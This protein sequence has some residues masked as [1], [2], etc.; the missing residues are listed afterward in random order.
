MSNVIVAC[1][2]IKCSW[3][4]DENIEKAEKLIS[5]AASK[6]VN[7]FLL[8][9]LFSTPYF[10]ST[11]D[12]NFF[13]L[14]RSFKNNDLLLKFSDIASKYK[15]VLPISFFEKDKNS[16]YNSV[17]IIDSN[18][19]IL[20]KYRKSHIPQNPGYEEKYYFS[21]GNTGFKVWDVGVC[22]FGVGIC[23]DQWFPECARSMVLNGADLLF[24]PT[25][26]GNE[27]QNPKINS[28]NHWQ[29]A[30][31]GHAASNMVGVIAS[32]RI[33]SEIINNVEM[34]FYGHSFIVNETGDIVKDLGNDKEGFICHTFNLNNLQSK[35][36]E[37]GLFRDRREDLYIN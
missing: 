20:G 30:M 1:S 19:S 27:P 16:Y 13:N 36:A 8:Q 10:C 6:N 32:N 31:R 37:W 26:I 29:T 25:A 9:E 28:K 33:G 4:Q 2:Q 12:P 21:P 24:Y 18:G 14:A 34:N 7:I 35:R 22:K 23:W 3:D 17:A 5:E 15:V 11:Q